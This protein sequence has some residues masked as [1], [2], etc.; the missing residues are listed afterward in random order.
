M[1]KRI[2][3]CSPQKDFFVEGQLSVRKQSMRAA[4][5]DLG[6]YQA[7]RS[8]CL[9]QPKKSVRLGGFQ[10]RIDGRVE[11]LLKTQISFGKDK[12]PASGE[13]MQ[14]WMEEGS[15]N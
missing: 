8:N 11:P 15:I 3:S 2:N 13:N 5:K 4:I 9:A 1:S 12:G 7:T 6:R 14:K 10:S